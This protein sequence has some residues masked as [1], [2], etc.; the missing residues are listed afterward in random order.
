[1]PADSSRHAP[2]ADGRRAAAPGDATNRPEA[3]VPPLLKAAAAGELPAW[4]VATPER[5]AHVTRVA[6]LLGAW[7]ETMGLDGSEQE[8]WRAAGMLHDALRDER[9]EV[10]RARVPV[11]LRGLPDALLH[12][13]AAAER[14]RVEGVLDGELLRAVAYHTVGD[15][16][17]R[18]LGRALYAA[19]FLEPGRSFLPEWRAEL[20]ARMPA[21]LDA[22][23]RRVVAA[24]L[25]HLIEQG[26]EVAPRTIAFWNALVAEHA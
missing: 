10:L 14:L 12:G 21:E 18:T 6:D 8:R 22:V 24:R 25:T 5:R 19:D 26:S 17:F 2:D 1:M 7:A 13:P 9:P 20:R 3:S 16:A 4:A 23:L 11:A 15:P